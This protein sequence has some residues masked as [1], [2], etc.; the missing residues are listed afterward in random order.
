MIHVTTPEELAALIRWHRANIEGYAYLMAPSV[1][2][3][4]NQTVKCLEHYQVI[5][6][7]TPDTPA[8]P[9]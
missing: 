4:E 5:L 2:H 8:E 1:L 3:L 6:H 9:Q 7:D